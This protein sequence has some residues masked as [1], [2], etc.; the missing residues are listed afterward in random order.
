MK[1]CLLVIERTE[2][3]ETLYKSTLALCCYCCVSPCVYLFCDSAITELN[4]GL[5]CC[6]GSRTVRQL[7]SPIHQLFEG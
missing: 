2:R 3:M 4:A 7:L 6:A 5:G 1:N